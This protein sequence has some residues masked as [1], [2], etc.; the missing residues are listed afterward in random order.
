MKKL[1]IRILLIAVL[2][3][4]I[5][6]AYGWVMGKIRDY[7]PDGRYYKARYTLE[8]AEEEVII[9]GSSRGERNY[10]SNQI[11]QALGMSCWNSSRGG[12]GLPYFRAIQEGLLTRHTPKLVI[13]NLEPNILEHSPFLQ[14]MGFLRSFYW[15]NKPI[16]KIINQIS[17]TEKWK[18]YSNIYAYNSSYYYLLRPYLFPGLDG[19]NSDK[20]WK[21]SYGYWKDPGYA[22]EI[23]NNYKLLDSKSV[24]LFNDL[25]EGFQEKGV[26]LIISISPNYGEE[27]METSSLTYIQTMAAAN[28]VPLFNFSRDSV[29]TRN[30]SLY[31]DIEHLNVDGARLFTS[32]LL[33]SLKSKVPDLPHQLIRPD[34]RNKHI[35]LGI[36]PS[37]LNVNL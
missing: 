6:Q 34:N 10:V 31:I 21:P 7:S 12:Q 18:I 28:N 1:G 8:E 17:A 25:L 35:K 4:A 26:Q 37:N 19:E 16:R 32:M 27:T 20:G 15:K 29:F 2:G 36:V 3:I 22:F 9:I 24:C 30:P 23:V 5:D 33:D 13:L 14:E 11:E